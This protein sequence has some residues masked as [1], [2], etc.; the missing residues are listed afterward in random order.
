MRVFVASG[1]YDLATPFFATDYTIAHL[2]LDPSQRG[3]IATAEYEAGHMMYIHE[4]ELAGCGRTWP[5]S[6][7]RPCRRRAPLLPE[8]ALVVPR[9]GVLAEVLGE[10]RVDLPVA[11]AH[12]LGISKNASTATPRTHRVVAP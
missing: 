5:P 12:H 7:P 11:A 8:A 2:G 1:H 6:S 3:R 4:G 9:G 10:D